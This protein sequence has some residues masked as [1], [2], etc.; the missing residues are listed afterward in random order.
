MLYHWSFHVFIHCYRHYQRCCY[1]LCLSCRR[2]RCFTK[3]RKVAVTSSLSKHVAKYILTYPTPLLTALRTKPELWEKVKCMV[4]ARCKGY[5]IL[6]FIAI[7]ILYR[8][9]KL[10]LVWYKASNHLHA[11]LLLRYTYIYPIRSY[12]FIPSIN[13]SGIS[14]CPVLS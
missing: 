5:L 1:Y 10:G 11:W 3:V 2:S 8:S 9:V 4:H 12:S 14:P 13:H 7:S 6:T